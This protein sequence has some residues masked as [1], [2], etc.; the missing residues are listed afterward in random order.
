[1]NCL[2][3]NYLNLFPCEFCTR[4]MFC[5]TECTN[6]AWARFH[7]YECPIIDGIF[8]LFSEST[9]IILGLR[10]T[11]YGLTMFDKVEK[12][13]NLLKFT[14]VDNCSNAISEQLRFL[15]IYSH[16]VDESVLDCR[17]HSHSC[18]VLWYFLT[19]FT[20][21][22]HLLKTKEVEDLFL[23]M[24]FRF[25][26]ISASHS[27]SLESSLVAA[28]E[29]YGTGLFVVSSLINHSCNPNVMRVTD[30]N[31]NV[32][33]VRRNIKKGE[34]IFDNYGPHHLYQGLEE[35]Q[36]VLNHCYNFKCDCEACLFNFPIYES[37][38]V[39]LKFKEKIIKDYKC[40]KSHDIDFI[41]QKI[42]EYSKYLRET[43]ETYP[44]Y[45]ICTVQNQLLKCFK[46]LLLVKPV[47]LY[48][49]L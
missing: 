2:K 26:V 45:Q 29:N 3:Q 34:Q 27:H 44:N 31:R 37:L 32:V 39:P 12:L 4:A 48:Q 24:L 18:A 42:T 21:L 46:A 9:H 5:S 16:K 8:A 22:P 40:I 47:N 14:N 11:I 25:G 33:I 36:R 20:N 19:L 6:K 23:N 13:E 38:S 41:R 1:M 28:A 43:S 49:R 35:R 7:K 17:Q 30:Y 15:S 10:T